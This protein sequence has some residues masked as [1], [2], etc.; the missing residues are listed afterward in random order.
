M[1]GRHL[2]G[3]H[4]RSRSQIQWVGLAHPKEKSVLKINRFVGDFPAPT[5]KLWIWTP[6]RRKHLATFSH[7][8]GSVLSRTKSEVL[9]LAPLTFMRVHGAFEN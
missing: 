5:E 8:G 2:M 4:Q 6:G 1:S 9:V 7:F 3:A